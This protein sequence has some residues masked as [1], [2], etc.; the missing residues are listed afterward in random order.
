MRVSVRVSVITVMKHSHML[1]FVTLVF[2]LCERLLA[3]SL[4]M[5]IV[6]MSVNFVCE[7]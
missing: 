7:V 4:D 6:H 5:R 2:Y 3:P 1:Q